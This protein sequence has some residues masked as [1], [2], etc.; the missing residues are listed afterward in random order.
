MKSSELW[1]QCASPDRNPAYVPAKLAEYLFKVLP[2]SAHSSPPYPLLFEPRLGPTLHTFVFL[3]ERPPLAFPDALSTVPIL[4]DIMVMCVPI[5]RTT[6][7]VSVYEWRT[8][9]RLVPG[10]ESL[11]LTLLFFK[12][13]LLVSQP[14]PVSYL[15]A[16]A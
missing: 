1:P 12:A 5:R 6:V 11:R 10:R 3:C 13:H 9:E 15:W 16:I 7:V 8:R 14:T 4:V 2:F